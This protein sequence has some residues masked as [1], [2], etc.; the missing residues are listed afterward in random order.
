[1]AWTDRKNGYLE[2]MTGQI[3]PDLGGYFRGGRKFLSDFFLSLECG[4]EIDLYRTNA[5][6]TDVSPAGFSSVFEHGSGTLALNV[7]LLM[8]EQA[9]FIEIGSGGNADPFSVQPGILL[10]ADR[11]AAQTPGDVT[12]VDGSSGDAANRPARMWECDIR[13]GVTVWS[14]DDGIAVASFFTFDVVAPLPDR[15]SLCP[16]CRTEPGRSDAGVSQV[17]WYLVFGEDR[18]SA[19][20]QACALVSSNG[21]A[22]HRKKIER[23]LGNCTSRSGDDRFDLAVRWAQ[24][25]AWMMVTDDHGIGI[26][27]GLPWFRDN[28]GR[29]TFISLSGTLL[30]SGLFSEAANVLRFFARHQNR[31]PDSPDYGRIP[32]RYRGADDVIYNTADG[33]LWFIRALWEYMQYTGDR[34]LLDELAGTV[35]LALKADME[36]R[37]DSHGF[38]LHGDA[39]T[40]MDARIRGADPWSP[41]GDR[42]NDIQALWYTALRIGARMARLRNDSEFADRC[43]A[44]ASRVRMSFRVFFWCGERQALADRLPP[45]PH[46]EWLRD[47]RVRPNQ[48]FAISVPSILSGGHPD[49]AA[50]L[51]LFQT[52]KILE[53][54]N[55]ELV[56]PFGLFTLSPDDPLFHPEHENPEWYH[57]DAAYHNGTIWP[58]LTG[59]YVSAAVAV[60]S[61]SSGRSSGSLPSFAGTILRSEADMILDR[62]CVGSLP[63][64]IHAAPD[65]NGNPVFSGTWS[66]TWSDAEFARNVY[67]DLI[68]FNPR[69]IDNRIEL[70]PHLPAGVDRWNAKPSFG[71]GWKL[72]IALER[73]AGKN[74]V[75]CRVVWTIS[76]DAVTGGMYPPLLINGMP[77]EPEKPVEIS[78]TLDAAPDSPCSVPARPAKDAFPGHDFARM[79]CG[80][81]HRKNYLERLIL[82]GRMKSPNGGGPNAAALEWLFDSD[83]FRNSFKASVPLGSSWSPDETVFRLWAP[84]ATSVSLVLYGDNG[85]AM[86]DDSGKIVVLP[87]RCGSPNEG[88]AGVWE[89]VIGGDLHGRYYRYRV[90]AHGIVR[91]TADP[92]ARACGVNGKHS[93][94]VDFS[95]TNP[96]G[97]ES[98]HAPRVVAP[99]DVVAYEVHI[100]DIT[101]SPFWSGPARLRRTYAGAGLPGTALGNV[102]TGFDHIRQLGVTH[103]QLMPVF[104]YSSVDE[105]RI[106]DPSYRNQFVGGVFNWGYDPENYTAPE[107]SF[108]T[109]PGNGAVRIT[110]LKDLVKGFIDSGIGVIMD[111]VYNH[112]P[113]AQNHPFGIAV[114]G[115]YFRVDSYSGAGDDTASERAMYRAYM[116]DSLSHWLREYKLSGFRFDL[117]GLHDVETMNAI[118][119]ALRRIKPD[120]LIYGEGWDMYR[121]GKTVAASMLESRKMPGIGFFNDAFRCGIKGSVFKEHEGGF[122]HDGSHREAV[123][124]GL[125]GS[126]FHP[127]VHNR[128]VDGT[129]NPNPWSDRTAASVNYTEIHDNSTLYDKL[130][131]VEPD[132]DEAYYERLQKT[133][134]SLVLLAQGMPILHAGMEFMRTKEIPPEILAKHPKL[135]DLYRTRDGSRAFSHN[136]YNLSDRVN[137]LDWSRC[138]EKKS[139]VDYTRNL[140][141]LRKKHS[142]FRLRTD[143]DVALS[144]S[145][146]EPE[147]LGLPAVIPGTAP[148]PSPAEPAVLAWVIASITTV[149]AWDSVCVVVNPGSTPAEFGLPPATNGGTWHL[150][151]DGELFL[152]WD[153]VSRAGFPRPLDPGTGITVAPKALY[154][155]AEF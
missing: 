142:L 75:R 67:Q 132:R 124:F 16:Q 81:I 56:S 19:V 3:G 151:T 88:K 23:F 153:G 83:S 57:K 6:H 12:S 69:L 53:N 85:S 7:S 120:V 77:L 39:D 107:G 100:A 52:E 123:K 106:H 66:Q 110:E 58:W 32:N 37:T 89:I 98:V 155:Y 44:F 26:W 149:D 49:D 119:S 36:R 63:E 27:A 54:V 144:L 130:V 38:L 116:I 152:D 70:W 140:I 137:G 122:I 129:A 104:D 20:N 131:L 17:S 31:N 29:D 91:D 25:S 135:N 146:I 2:L 48:L 101:S 50:L 95:R 30:V 4:G 127:Q 21:I 71:P 51:D 68:G 115:Y 35:E 118:S 18:A 78:F 76:P 10:A 143:D 22:A 1:M 103:V 92:S 8:D 55:R 114:P 84:T 154:L 87:M 94:V 136:T 102:P 43:D 79:W 42:A 150:V 11:F 46:G 147:L 126:V 41:R 60:S 138:A 97:W 72:S 74:R 73:D 9:F 121:G 82:G 24:F 112:V 62:G 133:A 93:M 13:D 28:W 34:V 14:S 113:A 148:A 47:F 80:S 99:N 134:I 45:G 65:A 40:W 128:D 141:S 139:V 61:A 111:V 90:R 86:G 117:M 59:P 109:C 96:D 33:T 105:S 145:F 5:L 64:N 125:V 15:L 108:S